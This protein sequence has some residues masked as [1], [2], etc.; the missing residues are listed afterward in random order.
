M[1]VLSAGGKGLVV[2]SKVVGHS[3]KYHQYF[4]KQSPPNL[5]KSRKKMSS[6]FDT[7]GEQSS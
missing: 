5:L 4:G 3:A 7:T 2:P 6:P 1:T